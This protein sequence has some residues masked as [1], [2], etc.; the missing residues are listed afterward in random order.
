MAE[1]IPI[2]VMSGPDL[3]A[4]SMKQFHPRLQRGDA[5]LH[6]SPYHGNTHAADHSILV[7]VIDN[8]GI[9]HFTVF[10]KAHQADCGN[11]APTTYSATAR[12]VYEEGALIFPCVKVQDNYTDCE[13]IIRMAKLRIRVPEQWWGDYL[14]LLG[15]TRI[16]EREMLALGDELGWGLLSAFAQQWFDYSEHQMVSAIRSLP[17]GRVTTTTAHDPYPGV[18]DG[19]P[20]KVTVEV[21]SDEALIEVD[22]RDNP[23]CLPCG[24]NMSEA[25]ARTA[26]ML[27]IFYSIGHIVTP[28]AGSA[29]RIK[30]HLRENCA[31]GIPRHPVS[32][33]VATTALADRVTNC[34]QRAIAE[35]AEGFG[36]AEAGLVQPPALGVISGHDPRN[37][38]MP[39]VNQLLLAAVN[40]GPGGP[41][42]DGWLTLASLGSAGVCLRDSVELDELRFPLRILAQHIIPDTEGAGRFRGTPGAYC[43]FGPTD[44]FLEVMYTSDGNVNPASGARGGLSGAPANQYKRGRSGEL[45]QLEQ[46]GRVVLQA[47][48]T[49]VS[50][51]CGGGG[52]GPPTERDP[53]RVR[54]D[55][56]EGWITRDRAEQVYGVVLTAAGEV[57]TVVTESVRRELTRRP[58]G[59]EP[60]EA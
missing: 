39:F 14:A 41:A 47:G 3:M 8:E 5:F 18:P 27:G 23:D 43:E 49:I 22:L 16:G 38:N 55:L 12:D 17:S 56:R 32:C 28:N 13:D 44:G 25:T 40:G 45:N 1:S 19:V 53:E 37:G 33:S 7:P 31:V 50:L 9:H 2:H 51:S 54:Q 26:P 6:N 20:I 60:A 59:A 36:L 46:C 30:V 24:L 21:K 52:Y 48:E 10:A 57:D 29:R 42:A 11:A 15:A 35:L 4:R 58:S 34:V